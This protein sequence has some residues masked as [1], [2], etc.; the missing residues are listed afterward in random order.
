VLKR[1]P[2]PAQGRRLTE[3]QLVVVL[4]RAG[5]QRR[6]TE[7]AAAI[8]DLLRQ[9]ALEQPDALATAYG[10]QVTALVRV[11]AALSA[12]IAELEAQLTEAYRC[13]PDAEIISSLP[14]LGVVLGARVLAEF[15]DDPTRYPDSRARKCYAGTAPVTRASGKSRTVSRRRATNK[16][17]QNACFLWAK[18]AKLSSPGSRACYWDL[19]G[20][21][22]GNAPAVRAL[23]NRLVGILDGCLRHRTLYDEAR[24]WPQL[25]VLASGNEPPGHQIK[26]CKTT[27]TTGGSKVSIAAHA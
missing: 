8:R 27:G 14:G 15:G 17:L 9:P 21:D 5:R 7:R 11:I 4:R 19:R 24:A 10:H 18:N 6:L 20:R 16:Q 3:A 2:T 13:H 26:S 25:T 12:Q 1:A 23:G 22:K